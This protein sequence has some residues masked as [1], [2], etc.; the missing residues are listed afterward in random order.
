MNT[1]NTILI[2]LEGFKY[3]VVIKDFEK[4]PTWLWKCKTV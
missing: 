1:S 2:S 3:Y 4:Y